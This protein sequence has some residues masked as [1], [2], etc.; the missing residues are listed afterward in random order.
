MFHAIR[1]AIALLVLVL[2]GAGF[3]LSSW[4]VVPAPTYSLLMLGVGAPEV[5]P[6]LILLN[7]AP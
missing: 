1:R 4:I 3:F 7:A 5:S 6:W 2:S